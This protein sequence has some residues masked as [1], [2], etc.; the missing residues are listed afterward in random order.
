MKPR[1]WFLPE[2]PDL[3]GMLR[4]QTV[5]TCEGVDALVAWAS[6]DAAAGERVRECEHRADDEKRALWRA[7]REAFTTPLDAEDLY[8]L[9]A[10][11]DEVLNGAKD[12]VRETEV[13]GI[14]PDRPTAEMTALL[15]EGVRYLGEAFDRLGDQAGD[16]T[17]PADAAVKAQRRVERVYRTA[18]SRLLEIEDLRE[19]MARREVYRRSARIGD[20]VHAVADRVWY[21]VVKEA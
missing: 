16:A 18:M 8:E 17:E 2:S 3:L 4:R 11:L 6:G 5:V 10:G 21:A 15:A 14:P 12:L 20:Q 1:R 13:M 9:S 19:V 7:L